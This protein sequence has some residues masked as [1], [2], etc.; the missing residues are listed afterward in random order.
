M[1]QNFVKR[2]ENIIHK[3]KDGKYSMITKK[4]FVPARNSQRMFHG[5]HVEPRL[6]TV[7]MYGTPPALKNIAGIYEVAITEYFKT[8]YGHK[9]LKKHFNTR[10]KRTA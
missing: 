1:A 4:I 10:R 6:E 8:M 2:V 3:E 5:V 7:T 9:K